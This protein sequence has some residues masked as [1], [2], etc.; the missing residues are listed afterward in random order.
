M[1]VGTNPPHCPFTRGHQRSRT[2]S[3]NDC[4][5][6]Y[7]AT[8]DQ[9]LR[10]NPRLTRMRLRRQIPCARAG[11]IKINMAARDA[12]QMWM[13]RP[14][15]KGR[16]HACHHSGNVGRCIHMRACVSCLCAAKPACDPGRDGRRR[17]AADFQDSGLCRA[18]R[19]DQP[20]RDPGAREGLSGRSPV[21]GGRCDQGGRSSLSHRKGP[22]RSRCRAGARRV[23]D[24]QGATRA[25]R[26]E[27]QATRR[28][29]CEKRK[30]GQG[31]GRS[32]LGR[33]RGEG[34]HH[35]Q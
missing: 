28:A 35:D 2:W 5:W 1:L 11:L 29:V 24:E 23:G 13:G 3:P 17:K 27:P 20:R 15:E 26:E 31:A 25:G 16:Q 9:P 19:G 7:R 21:Q 8:E 10:A 32:R 4:N 30:R 12:G 22:V 14:Q 18:H 33:G 34:G 6:S